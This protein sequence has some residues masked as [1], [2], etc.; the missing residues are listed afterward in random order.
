MSIVDCES[1]AIPELPIT[2]N[3][4]KLQDWRVREDV[5]A[6][7]IRG[8]RNR[9]SHAEGRLPHSLYPPHEYRKMKGRSVEKH[10]I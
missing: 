8:N 2:A 9:R 6:W 7:K 10:K 5:R 3:S 4:A 1:N